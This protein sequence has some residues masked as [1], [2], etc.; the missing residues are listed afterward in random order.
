MKRKLKEKI[1][2][3]R[4]LGYSCRKI[5]KDLNCSKSVVSYHCGDGQK[6]KAANHRKKYRSRHVFVEK[7]RVLY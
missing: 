4:T 5:A 1:L 2:E 6:E 7:V 3:L